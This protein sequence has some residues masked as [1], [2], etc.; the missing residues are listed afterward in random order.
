MLSRP[1]L[2]LIRPP[3]TTSLG[4]LG[5]T[6]N[7]G[8]SISDSSEL[9]NTTLAV[10][11]ANNGVQQSV[12]SMFEGFDNPGA[13][14]PQGV[15]EPL[16]SSSMH[17]SEEDR[18]LQDHLSAIRQLA[19]SAATALELLEG[20]LMSSQAK[21]SQYSEYFQSLRDMLF[22]YEFPSLLRPMKFI[23]DVKSIEVV[24]PAIENVWKTLMRTMLTSSG[25]WD[26]DG[27]FA[28]TLL[29]LMWKDC[30]DK[31]VTF[32][33]NAQNG[34]RVSTAS[35]SH[36]AQKFQPQLQ[37]QQRAVPVRAGKTIGR[38][39]TCD[40]ASV[41][42]EQQQQQRQPPLQQMNSPQ[43]ASKVY[44]TN[45]NNMDVDSE[46]ATTA[47]A[48]KKIPS[49]PVLADAATR[50][51]TQRND[52]QQKATEVKTP[53]KPSVPGVRESTADV[54]PPPAKKS[55]PS[56]VLDEGSMANANENGFAV[57][58]PL[59][60]TKILSPPKRGAVLERL[61]TQKEKQK[62]ES[63]KKRK[64]EIEVP[65]PSAVA[66]ATDV[67]SVASD[68]V[69][70]S[71]TTTTVIDDKSVINWTL[72]GGF[73]ELWLKLESTMTK[74]VLFLLYTTLLQCH[75]SQRPTDK[76]SETSFD[77]RF[78]N[79]LKK[80]GVV[81][82][83]ATELNAI[84]SRNDSERNA[85]LNADYNEM[86]KIITRIE[87]ASGN[88]YLPVLTRFYKEQNLN[89]SSNGE[90]KMREKWPK[91]KLINTR[92][93]LWV[94]G[95]VLHEDGLLFG[96]RFPSVATALDGVPD[97]AQ[98]PLVSRARN[99][100]ISRL[101]K[102]TR[103]TAVIDFAD[104]RSFDPAWRLMKKRLE[105]LRRNDKKSWYEKQG[106]L[107]RIQTMSSG[108]VDEPRQRAV[109]K[110]SRGDKNADAGKNEE[111]IEEV[112]LESLEQEGEEEE[113]MI[114]GSQQEEEVE[115]NECSEDGEFE[116]IQSSSDSDMSDD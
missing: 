73:A 9:I 59:M 12:D 98:L 62:K 68:E 69:Q 109:E 99:A 60:S 84:F 92:A 39:N 101:I 94:C 102:N 104:K 31:L 67:A 95:E 106:A 112:E 114:Q 48:V 5:C 103:I 6:T 35:A 15:G 23:P 45:G 105:D 80:T 2:A 57:K 19:T 30:P 52:K 108:V 96:L 89:Q 21:I 61:Q 3:K 25:Q 32:I 46:G 93:T 113:N 40:A 33:S 111:E 65:K 79:L 49:K 7:M 41:F 26:L 97:A 90:S 115:D 10:V 54:E 11:G 86:R 64:R 82:R 56:T 28:E 50:L 75:V 116:M 72:A 58:V 14:Q 47:Q 81:D 51:T 38:Q 13:S 17:E 8:A 77:M 42:D 83:V 91:I 1:T 24:V 18:E 63:L 74:D 44:S 87:R 100:R 16:E 71:D 110:S 37:Q 88:Y 22:K 27:N 4:T 34:P 76:R 85:F 43:I 55:K 66:S 107:N 20:Q 78:D 36:D 29:A 70:L 53:T